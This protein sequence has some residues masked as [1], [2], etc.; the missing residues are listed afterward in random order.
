VVEEGGLIP[1]IREKSNLL[2]PDF[3]QN[4]S[5]SWCGKKESTNGILKVLKRAQEQKECGA[6]RR[7][8]CRIDGKKGGGL[9]LQFELL[10]EVGGEADRVL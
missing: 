9:R 8:L 1:T 2:R 10:R 4:G 5:G 6:L 3:W 7:N